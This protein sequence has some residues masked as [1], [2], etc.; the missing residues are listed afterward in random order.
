MLFILFVLV[1]FGQAI[2]IVG[3]GG[4]KSEIFVQVFKKLPILPLALVNYEM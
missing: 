3:G 1:T 4:S 2:L